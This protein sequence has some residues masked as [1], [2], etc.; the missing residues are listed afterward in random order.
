VE[1]FLDKPFTKRTIDR[2]KK[3]LLKVFKTIRPRKAKGNLTLGL[4]NPADTGVV[5]GV[6][7][8]FLPVYSGFLKI[9]PDFYHQT[10]EGELWLKGRIQ[11]A[12]IAFPALNVVIHRDFK[13]TL[14][15]AK[16]I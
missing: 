9:E 11:L 10:V 12:R 13:R 2:G 16:K 5:I 3:C 15:L 4:S 14:A 6:I 1:C 7:S 8:M